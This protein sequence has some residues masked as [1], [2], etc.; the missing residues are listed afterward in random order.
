MAVSALAMP[1][2]RGVIHGQYQRGY[3]GERARL[4]EDGG[5]GLRQT[6]T[7]FHPDHYD[8]VLEQVARGNHPHDGTAKA[9]RAGAGDDQQW[10]AAMATA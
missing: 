8:A 1:L 9:K 3:E 6:S 5:I 4:V 10:R 2:W 7:A